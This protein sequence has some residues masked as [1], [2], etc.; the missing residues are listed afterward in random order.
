MELPG[1]LISALLRGDA[2]RPT[3]MVLIPASYV[4]RVRVWTGG[5]AVDAAMRDMLGANLAG[6]DVDV[7]MAYLANWP[8]LPRGAEAV[9][10]GAWSVKCART[11][12]R[13][14][15]P[16]HEAGGDVPV[17]EVFHPGSHG[18]DAGGHPGVGHAVGEERHFLK[19]RQGGTRR[20][21]VQ[22]VE[23][24]TGFGDH[25]RPGFWEDLRR[26]RG[27]EG[28]D[29]SRVRYGAEQL[30]HAQRWNLPELSELI[31]L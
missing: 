18:V 22:Q 24:L 10:F 23:R 14:G 27:D 4:T 16:N 20:E 13:S 30:C 17:R 19:R 12:T 28:L 31:W 1:L 11:L 9:T 8:A 29:M 5:Q 7:T 26:V 6:L 21:V 25:V 2:Q 15:W 3:S